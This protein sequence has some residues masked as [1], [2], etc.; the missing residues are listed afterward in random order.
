[1]STSYFDEEEF[2]TKFNSKVLGRILQLTIPHKNWVI[3]FLVTIAVVAGL[4]SVTTY[5]SK[6]IIDNGILEGN[7]QAL[8]NIVLI[9][10]ATILVQSASTFLFI[11][12]AGILGERIRYDLRKKMFNHLQALSLDYYSKTPVGWIMARVSSD[13]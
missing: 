7:K 4:D 13:S 1:M 3:G 2:E 9:Y 11:Y 10:G 12:L 8:T 5:L 6:L